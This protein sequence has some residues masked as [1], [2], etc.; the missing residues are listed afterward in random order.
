VLRDDRAWLFKEA[1]APV[2]GWEV[3]ARKELVGDEEGIA[4]VADATKLI[5]QGK[6]PGQHKEEKEKGKNSFFYAIEEFV[7]CIREN[8][9]PRC[10]AKEGLQAAIVALKANEAAQSGTKVTFKPEWFVV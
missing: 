3:Y 4:L 1:D 7:T 6:I 9:K 5:A 2:L 8:E 10:G